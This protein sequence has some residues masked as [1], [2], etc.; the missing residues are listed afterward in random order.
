[1]PCPI[2]LTLADTSQVAW[3]RLA[4][5]DLFEGHLD[6]LPVVLANECRFRRIGNMSADR[7][8]SATS[9]IGRLV[10]MVAHGTLV[11]LVLERSDAFE[12]KEL[13]N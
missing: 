1:M 8:V 4:H 13:D 2:A 3:R 7:L 10:G 5:D 6:N 12:P 9:L 11:V